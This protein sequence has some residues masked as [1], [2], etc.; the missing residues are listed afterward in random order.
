MSPSPVNPGTGDAHQGP[1]VTWGLD[2][3]TAFSLFVARCLSHVDATGCR[4]V[5]RLAEGIREIH[6][7]WDF[8][9]NHAKTAGTEELAGQVSALGWALRCIAHAAWESHPGWDASFRPHAV[10]PDAPNKEGA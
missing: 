6:R 3:D 9:R 4:D 10:A 8:K 7:E 1:D 5:R 2:Q